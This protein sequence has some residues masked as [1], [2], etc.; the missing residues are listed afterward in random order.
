MNQLTAGVLAKRARVPVFTVRHY[1]KIGL[2]KPRKLESNGYNVFEDSDV[3]LLNFISIAKDLG[4][5]LRE[6]SEILSMSD[7]GES[8]CPRVREIIEA[9]IR[10]N[11]ERITKLQKL[12]LRI[13]S[14]AAAWEDMPDKV[15][16]GHSVCHLIES[17]RD[18][19]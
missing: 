15:P 13:E 19:S 1:T 12:Q 16:D 7:H 8:P 18:E 3:A 17:L 9:R 11:A 4:F 14:A 2:L 6:I 10:E 5:T